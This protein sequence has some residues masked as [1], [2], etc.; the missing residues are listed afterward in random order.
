MFW[1]SLR[2]KVM[3][4]AFGSLRWSSPSWMTHKL[5]LH[6]TKP[7]GLSS[8]WRAGGEAGERNL[9]N[10]KFSIE[11]SKQLSW[12][13]CAVF[14]PVVFP[15]W[16]QMSVL[17]HKEQY[18]ELWRSKYQSLNLN[19]ITSWEMWP[20]TNYLVLLNFS[21]LICEVEG[22]S[23]SEDHCILLQT[24]ECYTRLL[25]NI[26]VHCSFSDVMFN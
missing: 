5:C 6:G 15:K 8:Q 16:R 24:L 17:A 14:Q 3:C 7:S 11:K 19:F 2:L 21:F 13:F 10:C 1:I 23:V 20:W 26:I 12:W 9:R 4:I 18:T 25:A 22:D